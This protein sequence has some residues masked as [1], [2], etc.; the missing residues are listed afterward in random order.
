MHFAKITDADGNS[1]VILL[2][3][4]ILTTAVDNKSTWAANLDNWNE[5]AGPVH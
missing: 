3:K 5:T 4:A 1:Y 2:T